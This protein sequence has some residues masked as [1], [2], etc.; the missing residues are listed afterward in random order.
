MPGMRPRE[1]G[2]RVLAS[3]L[4]FLV[5]VFLVGVA[6]AVSAQ[7]L[8]VSGVAGY[9]SEWQLSGSVT[10]TAGGEFTG[11]LAIKHIGLCSHDGPQEEVT[12]IR[13]RTTGFDPRSRVPAPWSQVQASFI[14]EGVTCAFGGRF[15]GTYT[16]FMDCAGAKGVP[17]TL[18]VK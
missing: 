11:P 4:L 5:A 12:E 18:S 17:V 9:L 2:L 6:G 14:M 3:F 13:L 7:P 8:T 1:T 15:S 10:E 16:G